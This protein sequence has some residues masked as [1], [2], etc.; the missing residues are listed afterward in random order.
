MIETAETDLWF[1]LTEA[2]TY[3]IDVAQCLS[4]VNRKMYRQGM[5]YAVENLEMFSNG[6]NQAFVYR[7]PTPGS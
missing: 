3:Y 1:D 5:Q 2:G 4:L 6:T 7:L